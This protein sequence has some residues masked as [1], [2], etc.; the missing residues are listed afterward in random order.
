LMDTE[1]I[2]LANGPNRC[3]GRVEVEH[4]GQ[5]GTVCD[6]GWDLND[7]KVICR[8]LG[9]GTAVAA[10]GQA[11][12]GTG[13]DPIWLDNVECAGTET[14]FRQCNRG[15]WGLHNCNHNEDAGVVCAGGQRRPLKAGG[16]VGWGGGD[17]GDGNGHNGNNGN[18]F[19]FFSMGGM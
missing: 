19:V 13:M 6:D 17:G 4:E 2:R 15:S 1:Q 7:A 3:A 5:W 18:V 11:R 8:Q 14:A 10:P 9:C 12:F 16:D